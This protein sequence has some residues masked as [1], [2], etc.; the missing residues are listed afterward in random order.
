MKIALVLLVSLFMNML[1]FTA[2]LSVDNLAESIGEDSVQFFNYEDSHISEFDTGNGTYVLDDEV[3][4]K[5]PDGSG[6]IEADS[7]N[8]FTDTFATVK[9]WLLDS[10]GAKYVIKAVNALPNFVAQIMP[11]GFKEL[12]FALGYLWHAITVFLLIV[13]L[14]G[15]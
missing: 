11:S 13:W 12:G 6:E 9:N 15:G 3:S 4:T 5:L 2:Q 10:T 1:L 7:G 14:K 8:I